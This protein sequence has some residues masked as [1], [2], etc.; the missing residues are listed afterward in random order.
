MT[1]WIFVIESKFLFSVTHLY[2]L[3]LVE[4]RFGFDFELQQ[5]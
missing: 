3:G 5:G 1:V 4:K 2:C